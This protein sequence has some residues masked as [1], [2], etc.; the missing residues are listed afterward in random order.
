MQSNPFQMFRQF[1]SLIDI[2][3]LTQE[4]NVSSDA[5]ICRITGQQNLASLKQMHGNT[6]VCVRTPTS[7]TLEAD[8]L[9]TDVPGLA[10][11][12]RF[13]DCQNALILDVQERVVCL[14][15]AGW[16]GVRSNVFSH[17]YDLLRAKWA[18][19]PINTFVAFGPSLC[20]KCSTFTDPPTEV[21]ELAKFFRQNNTVDLR[22]AAEDELRGIGV[23]KRR[24]ERMLDCPCCHPETYFT[25]RGGDKEKVQQGFTNC[26]TVAIR[27]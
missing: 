24:I 16:R 20:R 4:D 9:A 5:D 14:V 15:H 3:L 7:R 26:L 19:D 13:A 6:A 11:S 23:Q 27:S 17:A 2:R 22:D 12:V 1:Q 21:P 18:I 8:A 10:L 25:Y